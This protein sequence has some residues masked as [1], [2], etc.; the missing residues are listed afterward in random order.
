M[1][2]QPLSWR[3]LEKGHFAPYGRRRTDVATAQ[4]NT[5]ADRALTRGDVAQALGDDEDTAISAIMA[6]NPTYGEFHTALAWALGESDVMGEERRPLD[7][8]AKQI[9]DILAAD[10]LWLADLSGRT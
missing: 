4:P 3:Q 10:E 7:G 6:L 8:K 2:A 5:R 1:P 9:Y